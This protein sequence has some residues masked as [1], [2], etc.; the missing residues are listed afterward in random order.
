[1]EQKEHW[2][3]QHSISNL[4]LVTIIALLFFE[5][6]RVT[7]VTAIA[8]MDRVKIQKVVCAYVRIIARHHYKSSC[9]S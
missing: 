4:H 9:R 8:S 7:L 2:N 6:L 1:M 3:I 5:R